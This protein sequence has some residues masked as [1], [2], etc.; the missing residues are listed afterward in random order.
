MNET[1]LTV[2]NITVK[3]SLLHNGVR[4]PFYEVLNPFHTV[5]VF[6][7]FLNVLHI[8]FKQWRQTTWNRITPWKS[9][10]RNPYNTI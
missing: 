10:E 8:C 7:I 3:I 5:H 4:F 9:S 2:C 1:C 6:Y